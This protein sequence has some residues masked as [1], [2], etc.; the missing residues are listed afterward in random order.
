VYISDKAYTREQILAAEAQMLCQLDFRLTAPSALVFLKRFTKIARVEQKAGMARTKTDH[1]ANYM[2]E[3]AQQDYNMLQY[4]LATVAAAAISLALQTMGAPAWVRRR[5]PACPPACAHAAHDR[6]PPPPSTRARSWSSTRAS[7]G[8]R[9]SRACARCTR[10]TLRL[11]RRA[12]RQCA[13]STRRRS[14]AR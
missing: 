7:S 12:C 9:C 10:C 3:L 4:P 13:R 11:P 6:P 5:R 1:L 8:R 14:R 2:L